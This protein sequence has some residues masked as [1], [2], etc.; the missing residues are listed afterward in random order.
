MRRL[1]TAILFAIVAC[2]KETD[3]LPVKAVCQNPLAG[4]EIDHEVRIRFSQLPATMQPFELE[5]MARDGADLHASF[6]MQ[7]MEMG[8]NRYRLVREG[9]KWRARVML[10]ACIQGRRD[11]VLLLE[12]SGKF[13]EIPF[14]AG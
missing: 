13:Y 3:A 7:G 1:F 8:M 11:W 10:P 9:G 2:T 6:Q 12:I 5:V 4:C 14:V